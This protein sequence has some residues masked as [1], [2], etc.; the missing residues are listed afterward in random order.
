MPLR[1]HFRPPV[2]KRSSWEELHGGWPMV[3]VQYLRARLPDGYTAAPRLHL[4]RMFEVDIA[5][6]ENQSADRRFDFNHG[7]GGVAT[8]PW[9]PPQQ[10]LTVETDLADL[11]AYEVRVYDARHERRLVAA[12]EIVSPANKD[13]EVHRSAFIAKCAAMLQKGVAVSIVD[14]VTIRSVNLYTEMLRL[15][16]QTDPKLGD[17]PPAIYATATRCLRRGSRNV[18]ESWSFPLEVSQPLPTLPLWLED[19][20]VIPLDLE[21]TYEQACHDVWI[22]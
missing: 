14:L 4:G 5:A 12:I 13:R 9:A 3:I 17:P 18:L 16:G 10:S 11:D 22:S 15:V 1:D 19:D 21:P 20:L 2:S 7:D 6:L 8:L